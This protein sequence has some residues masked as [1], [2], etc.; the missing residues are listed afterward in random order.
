M[1]S[2]DI[3]RLL[4]ETAEL[5]EKERDAERSYVRPRA[6]E[7]P[8]QVYSLRIPVERLEQLRQL[9][10][11]RNEAPTTM[12][13]RWVLERL[14]RELARAV[15]REPVARF[16]ELFDPRSVH[17]LED[18]LES[19]AASREYVVRDSLTEKL[20]ELHTQLY[21][22]LEA[23]VEIASGRPLSYKQDEEA[24]EARAS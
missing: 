17:E 7:S 8:S 9:A 5:A 18:L 3:P 2:P 12:M 24:T 4:E 14:D 1:S 6:P 13:R 15:R 23:F 19:M 22:T 20:K 21:A 11:A 16:D 10:E